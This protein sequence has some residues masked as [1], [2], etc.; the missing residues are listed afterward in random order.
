MVLILKQL[1]IRCSLSPGLLRRRHPE[2]RNSAGASRITNAMLH[3][4]Y[5]TSRLQ[6]QVPCMNV[7]QHELGGV[8]L[9]QARSKAKPLTTEVGGA[10]TAE[11]SAEAYGTWNQKKA[12]TPPDHP[13]SDEQKQRLKQTLSKSFMLLGGEEAAGCAV[14]QRLCHRAIVRMDISLYLG[15]LLRSLPKPYWRIQVL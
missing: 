5:Y 8:L 10:A 4:S 9:A 6:H 11:V 12:F 13:K 14:R 1:L 2:S 7:P 3:D 15:H